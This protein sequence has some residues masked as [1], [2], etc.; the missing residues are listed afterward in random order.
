MPARRILVVVGAALAAVALFLLGRTT[1]PTKTVT[2]QVERAGKVVASAK[3]AEQAQAQ[4]AAQAQDHSAFTRTIIRY[5]PAP[6]GGCEKAEEVTET[7]TAD[8]TKTEVTRAS[9]SK[10]SESTAKSEWHEHQLLKLVEAARPR[11]A[12]GAAVGVATDLRPRYQ[13]DGAYRIAGG[14]SLTGAVQL[15]Q[16]TLRPALFVG[17]RFEF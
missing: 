7:G 8:S 13:I 2:V 15:E 12:V 6:A 10:T 14:L 3:A 17:G 5:R 16:A 11:W 1:A 4:S 9:T